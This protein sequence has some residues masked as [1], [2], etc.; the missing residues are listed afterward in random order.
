MYHLPVLME[1]KMEGASFINYE[2]RSVEVTVEKQE[3]PRINL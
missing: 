1:L 3:V 2:P